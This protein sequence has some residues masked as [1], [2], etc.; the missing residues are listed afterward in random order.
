MIH[1]VQT[2]PFIIVCPAHVVCAFDIMQIIKFKTK[3]SV[4]ENSTLS[5]TST[6]TLIARGKL[7][8]NLT[9]RNSI[10]LL[11]KIRN[12]GKLCHPP[13]LTS[14]LYRTYYIRLLKDK[15]YTSPGNIG[16]LKNSVHYWYGIFPF[17]TNRY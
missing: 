11:I 17:P 2:N 6:L 1:H 12:S 14:R 10:E 7:L 8:Y 15:L 5:R 4:Y 9:Q 16:A 13:C 3:F